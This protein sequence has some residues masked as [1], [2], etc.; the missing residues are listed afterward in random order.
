MTYFKGIIPAFV[1]RDERN[2][3]STE[4]ATCLA[5]NLQP[6]NE[7]GMPTTQALPI[8]VILI[9]PYWGE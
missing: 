9:C 5:K 1:S 3:T 7:A 8:Y 6:E 4:T 2:L